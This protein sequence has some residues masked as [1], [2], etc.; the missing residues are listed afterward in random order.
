MSTITKG[1]GG[2]PQADPKGANT[3]HGV[4]EGV[5]QEDSPGGYGGSDRLQ[6]EAA[7]LQQGDKKGAD[8]SK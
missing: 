7:P 6:S 3:T 5:A 1:P 8:T 4:P 2:P